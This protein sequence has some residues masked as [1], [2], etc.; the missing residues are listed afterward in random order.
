MVNKALSGFA[1]TCVCILLQTSSVAAADEIVL[2]ASDATTLSGNWTRAAEPSAAGGQLLTTPDAGW[3]NTSGPLALP[4]NFAQF[5]FAADANT[6][7]RVW[8][9]LRAGANSKYNDSIFA[10][11]SD[12]IDAS[13]APLYRIGTTNGLAIN[14]QSCNGCAMSGWGWLNSAYWLP[15]SSTVRFATSGSRTLRLQTRE[16]G[17]QIDQVV[18]SPATYATQAPGPIMNDQTIVQKTSA[19]FSGTRAQLPGLIQAEDFDTGSAGVAY[20]DLAAGNSGGA[21]RQ[22]DVDI[23]AATDGGYDIG[24]V[25]PGEWLSYS[26]NVTASGNYLL[27][28]R[29]ASSGQGGTFHVESGSTNITGPLSIPNTGGWQRWTSVSTLVSLNAGPQTMRLVFDTSTA[30]IVGNVTWLRVSPTVGTPFTNS[31]AQLPG[32]IAA[33]DFDNGG[34]GLGFHDTTLANSGG[35]YRTTAV[36]IEGCGLGGYNVGWTATGEWLAY[37]VNVATAGTFAIRM[38]VASMLS[39]SVLRLRFGSVET[40]AVPVP[41]TGGW[42]NWTTVEF[43]AVLTAGAQTMR[44][45]VESGGFN[46]S[47]I[48]AVYVP[49]PPPPTTTFNVAAGDNLQAALNAAEAGDTILLEAGAT[50]VG[51]FVLPA[52]PGSQYITIRSS[53]PDSLLPPAGARIGPSY[54][55]YLPKLMSPNTMPALATAPGAHHY[56]LLFLE[57]LATYQGYND[58]VTLG[59]GSAAQNT[60]QSVPHHL[61]VDRCYLHGDPVY[62]QKRG[63]ALNSSETSILNSYIVEIKRVGQDSQAISGWNGPGPFLIENNYLEAA[64]ENIMFGGAPPYIQNLVPSDI[65]VR[66]NHL[67]K[68]LAW[69]TQNWL[70]KNLFELKNAQRVLIDGNLMEYNWLS[71]QSGYAI[72]FTPRNPGGTAPWSV[73]QHVEFTNNIVRH[74]AGG[75]NILG[76]DN[77]STTQTTNHIVVRNNLFE[78]V[79]SAAYGGQGRFVMID[80]GY[81]ITID[82]NTVLQDGSTVLYALRAVTNFVFTN[83]IVPDN[84]WAIM[85]NG[86]GE[87][88]PSIATYFPGSTIRGNVIAGGNPAQYPSG[89]YFPSSLTTVGF[90]NLAGANYRLTTTSA[91]VSG[92]TDGTDP[93]ANIDLMNTAAGTQY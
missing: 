29:V 37:S 69:R 90:M 52:K 34:E 65:V 60:L 64:A 46:V 48:T 28:A 59:D 71:G 4:T 5:T 30:G 76:N 11:F 9:R 17:F 41:N 74:V 10:Q 3:S 33:V 47:S 1:V 85:G 42:Q 58:I 84:N 87:G 13:G 43:P 38:Q 49:P 86:S 88:N 54:A 40:A 50:F 79:S 39:T 62:G 22:T 51:N 36:D 83:N 12:A 55:A 2:Y 56:R 16:D 32:T 72:L 67:T 35:Q 45:L 91:C 21:Y 80:G 78:D 15:Q 66:R 8:V 61:I 82:H 68:P 44:L 70:V 27:E 81:D 26:V 6:N 19:A 25:S 92:A 18:L 63:I 31:P 77:T 14:L 7:Y 73:V 93:G 20:L 53:A 24:W 89:N 23:E 75:F 57:F